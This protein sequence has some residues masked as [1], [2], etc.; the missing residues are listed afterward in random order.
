MPV[1]IIN[2]KIFQ[3]RSQQVL[4]PSNVGSVGDVLISEKLKSTMP[5]EFRWEYQTS[6]ALEPRFGANINNGTSLSFTSGGGPPRVFDTNWGGKRD[7]KTSVGWVTQD[8]RAV[9]RSFYPILGE[10]PQYAW[11]NKIANVERQSRTGELFK[12]SPPGLITQPTGPIRGGVPKVVDRAGGGEVSLYDVI[13]AGFDRSQ[14]IGQRERSNLK[15]LKGRPI[16]AA[17]RD[18]RR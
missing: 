3:I 6:G 13:D 10:T 11:R 2:D 7:M 5:G 8:I 17:P 9:D 15:P 1:P 18:R 14:F 16:L 12:Y 4:S